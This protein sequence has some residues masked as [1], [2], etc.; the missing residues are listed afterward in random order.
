VKK[1]AIAK[2]SLISD[3]EFRQIVEEFTA[4]VKA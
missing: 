3:E 1:K 4:A 2:R